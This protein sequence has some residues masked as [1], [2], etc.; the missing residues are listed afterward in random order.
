[1]KRYL[2]CICIIIKISGFVNAQ[3]EN[4]NNLLFM[5]EWNEN[6]FDLRV[7]DIPQIGIFYCFDNNDI[8]YRLSMP[9]AF[10]VFLITPINI[11]YATSYWGINGMLLDITFSFVPDEWN[12]FGY[13]M[14]GIK[15]SD[16]I[17]L[18]ILPIELWGG[19]PLSHGGMGI[20]LLLEF[21]SISVFNTSR[22][23]YEIMYMGFGINIGIKYILSRNIEF[24][25]KYENYF[26]YTD[27]DIRKNYAGITFKYRLFEPGY[28]G[29]W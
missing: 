7:L 22:N 28:Y 12:I 14:T 18:R 20:Y 1:M 25:I 2:I 21:A 27:I 19:I 15:F 6:I 5:N 23:D 10:P 13:I 17:L 29:I 26:S 9:F 8:A 4:S 24:E 11:T 16:S 3:E